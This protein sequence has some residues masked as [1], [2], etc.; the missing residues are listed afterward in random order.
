M[1]VLLYTVGCEH[2]LKV[3]LFESAAT[4]VHCRL[5]L[6]RL[7]TTRLLQCFENQVSLG[8]APNA[9]PRV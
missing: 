7:C 9:C 5:C 2:A 3:A 8:E 4:E 1:H 6:H